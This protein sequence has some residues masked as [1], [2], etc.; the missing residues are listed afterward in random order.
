MN[1]LTSSAERFSSSLPRYNL[2]LLVPLSLIFCLTTAC[3]GFQSVSTW[4]A[5]AAGGY[6][7]LST[8][9]DSRSSIRRVGSG[10]CGRQQHQPLMMATRDIR[11]QGSKHSIPNSCSSGSRLFPQRQMPRSKYS[12]LHT[13][14][15]LM[16][17]SS[18]HS[19]DNNDRKPLVV[20]AWLS[21]R[22]LL[23]GFWALLL[24]PFQLLKSLLTKQS[25]EIN[26]K[27]DV[28]ATK[29][30]EAENDAAPVQ[31]ELAISELG[32][33][34]AVEEDTKEDV[35]D[36]MAVPEAKTEEAVIEQP[37]KEEPE[38]TTAAS[39]PPPT[40]V[41]ESAPF[42]EVIKTPRAATTAAVSLTGNWTLIV[43]ESFT[44]Q[45]ENYLRKLGQP[46]L[47]R[48]VAQTVIGSTKEETIQSDDG[49]KLFIRG[50]NVRG[51]WER[52]L[53]ASE[54]IDDDDSTAV[55]TIGKEKK[56][57]VQGHEL[58]PMTTADG[59]DVEVASWWE[60]NGQVHH[61]W[62]VGGKKYGGGDFET[63]RFLTDNGNILVCES[64]FHPRMRDDSTTTTDNMGEVQGQGGQEVEREKASVTW[65]FLREGAIYGDAK[66]EFPNIFDVFS[67]EKEDDDEIPESGV[68][69]GDIMDNV[70]VTSDAESN[71][72][73]STTTG[74]DA[75]IA[76]DAIEEA[77]ERES[78]VPP[79]GDRWSIAAPNVDLTGKWKLI[80]TE[81][82]KK[83]YEEF[84]ISLGQP[85]IVRAAAVVLVGNTREETQQVDGGRSMY[86]KGVNA[87][88]TWERRLKAS[89]SDF[90][91]TMNPDPTD[92]SYSH[93]RVAIETAD[94]EKVEAESWWENNGTVHVS[95]TYGVTRYG[96][97]SFESKRYLEND[98]SVYVCESTFHPN[99]SEQREK[100][101]LK[102]K[103][104]REGAAFMVN[105]QQ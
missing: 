41:A 21:L 67:D 26:D 16:A 12:L 72:E 33:I 66:V 34:A 46:M 4:R 27:N 17:A 75:I 15:M 77:I 6:G 89:G 71:I 9:L 56:H 23:A 28:Q 91:S 95:W 65:R 32:N 85:I 88:G 69:V 43:D 48:T 68:I 80:I 36:V 78:W 8:E 18:D 50:L 20:N 53:E 19:S 54:Q 14:P 29:K 45:Y 62:V 105:D 5:S 13:T 39:V 22:K 3:N 35:E 55:R 2:R 49:Q 11:I 70:A 100:S 82:F 52:T 83:D 25:K 96:G 38:A 59:E 64:T 51:S 37:E 102:W 42:V 93:E 86:I 92:G 44:S 84:L 94:S 7:E 47:V 103:F 98:G 63:K 81:Q 24:K 73:L 1:S 79:S 10:T 97:G 76:T 58:K 30:D 90:G 101:Y 104:L 99:D 74:H 60:N 87:K 31:E 61:S 57:A 40:T